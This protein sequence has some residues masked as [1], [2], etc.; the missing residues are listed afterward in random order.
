M[1]GN[2]KEFPTSAVLWAL[3]LFILPHTCVGV[4]LIGQVLLGMLWLVGGDDMTGR[5]TR[6]GPNSTRGQ[7]IITWDT[8]TRLA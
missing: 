5:I 4:F 8:G 7:R 2:R 3:R 6:T 1:P